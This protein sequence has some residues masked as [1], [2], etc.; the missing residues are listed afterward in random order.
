MH[1]LI[2]LISIWVIGLKKPKQNKQKNPVVYMFKKMK[3]RIY[4]VC[5][6]A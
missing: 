3:L 5:L 1:L 6:Q 2:Q 4:S